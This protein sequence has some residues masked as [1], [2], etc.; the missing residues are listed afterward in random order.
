MSRSATSNSQD[1]SLPTTEQVRAAANMLG[2]V[3][4][5]NVYAVVGGAACTL[6]GSMRVT[7]DVDFVVPK[8]STSNARKLLKEQTDSF[9]V[10]KKTFHTIYKSNPPV[11]I[12]ILAP[13][14]LFKERFDA[15]TPI[16]EVD[17]V[18]ILKPALLLNAKCGS[19]L[20]RAEGKK[21]DTDA[22]DIKYLLVWCAL[23]QNYPT[24]EE[25]PNASKEFVLWF[26][27]IYQ[28]KEQWTG[29]RYVL[30]QG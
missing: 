10:E 11:E 21:K 20:S 29:A 30:E 25:V 23:T 18:K 15:S 4:G 2:Y 6:L 17:G 12:E 1:S 19:I 27:R 26:I 3:L 13:P 22:F 14:A 8:G 16:T 9:E 5:E 28:G 7:E 24:T